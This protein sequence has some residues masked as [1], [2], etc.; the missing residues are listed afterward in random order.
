MSLQRAAPAL[1]EDRLA[2]L[3]RTGGSSDVSRSTLRMNYR[4][5]FHAGNFADVVKHAVLARVI[6]HLRE[7]ETPFRVID[8]HAGAGLTRLTGPEASRTGEWQHGI[9]RVIGAAFAPD[10]RVLLTP[11]LEAIAKFNRTARS[12][13]IRALRCS[14]W[15]GCASRIG[16]WRASSCP[17]SLRA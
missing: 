7:K 13:S 8:T 16:F 10:A 6:A 3:D 4:H 11:Y 2:W 17:P 9:G 12:R 5:A 14:C 15:H 1:A